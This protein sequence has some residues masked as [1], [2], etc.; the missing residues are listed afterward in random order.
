MHAVEGKMKKIIPVCICMF[1]LGSFCLYGQTWSPIIRLTWNVGASSFPAIA[2]NIGTC[3]HLVWHD[4]SFGG[5]NEIYY[6]R[7]TDGGATWSAAK[8]LTWTAGNSIF[9]A[10]A[11]DSADG[12]HLVWND[13]TSGE[14]EVYYKRSTDGGVTWSNA[15]RLTWTRTAYGIQWGNDPSIAVD[16]GNGIY[17]A[18][19]SY[20]SGNYEIYYKRST[21]KGQTWSAKR[22]LTWT[23]GWSIGPDIAVD[24]NDNIHIVWD[25]Y[26]PGNGEIFYKSSTDGG[27]TWSALKRLTWNADDSGSVKI[28]A[29]LGGGIHIAWTDKCPEQVMYKNSLDGGTNWSAPTQLTWTS[30]WSWFSEIAVLDTGVHVVW[31]EY[32]DVNN[33]IQIRYKSSPYLGT[34]WG[35]AV[36]LTWNNKSSTVPSVAVDISGAVHVVWAD[37]N[38]GNYE[39]YYKYYK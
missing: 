35:A 30:D 39:I 34:S 31:D 28:A 9:P 7:S 37:N 22:R 18:W 32:D 26:T 36:Q 33:I 38:P 25:D 13:K 27:T 19:D 15:K 23:S 5:N 8:R 12:V 6:K 4:N 20:E 16:S 10:V 1:F 14:D 3:L 17:V 11:I 29:D 21:D 2:R 24:I